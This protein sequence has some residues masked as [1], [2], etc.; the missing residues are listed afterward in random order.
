M[1]NADAVVVSKLLS[2]TGINLNLVSVDRDAVL[3]E[4]VN[5]IP[6][7]AE[8]PAAGQKLLRALRQREQ[9]HSTGVGDG[10][11]LPHARDAV[12]GLVDRPLI[13]FGRHAQGIAY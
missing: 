12:A 7:L 5:Q 8:Q 6:Q 1:K 9:L 11:A 2:P 4:L 10:V 13:V 3:G